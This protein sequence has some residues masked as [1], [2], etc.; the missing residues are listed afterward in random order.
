MYNLLFEIF[1]LVILKRQEIEKKENVEIKEEAKIKEI[2]TNKNNKHKK[3][4]HD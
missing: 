1:A 4:H 3:R 2:T